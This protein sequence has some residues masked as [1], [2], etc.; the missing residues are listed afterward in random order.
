MGADCRQGCKTQAL[1]REA[2]RTAAQQPLQPETKHDLSDT[3]DALMYLPF[4]AEAEASQASTPPVHLSRNLSGERASR[5]SSAWECV[6]LSEVECAE[7]CAHANKTLH[8]WLSRL[9]LTVEI[10]Q[11][12]GG[13]ALI[14]V[15]KI[16]W[17]GLFLYT[18]N[19]DGR[20]REQKIAS[21]GANQDCEQWAEAYADWLLDHDCTP[22][23]DCTH[24]FDGATGA[25]T[26]RSTL[27][28]DSS[29]GSSSRELELQ[30]CASCQQQFGSV[31]LLCLHEASECTAAVHTGDH[32]LQHRRIAQV[33]TRF[34]LHDSRCV[35][36]VQHLASAAAE[37]WI[38]LG[39]RECFLTDAAGVKFKTAVQNV[40]ALSE[41]STPEDKM[42]LIFAASQQ[43]MAAAV[44]LA[45]DDALGGD[46]LV[47]LLILCSVRANSPYLYSELRYIEAFTPDAELFKD[48]FG[49]S[50]SGFHVVG[51]FLLDWHSNN[52]SSICNEGI[53]S[54][55]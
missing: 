1:Q 42:A 19:T 31:A 13:A 33:R 41:T 24:T 28:L 4:A 25:S 23:A 12:G 30:S 46:D 32:T 21:F 36:A 3:V 52:C 9:Q 51:D 15:N 22:D 18:R 2:K 29:F 53:N 43:I 10:E 14:A 7:L 16:V 35:E 8:R 27:Q 54:C 50:Y 37:V 47:P 39:V 20:I 11:R 6:E 44:L 45:S 48:E 49:Y 38:D 5:N 17:H 40:Q 26:H 34:A 55:V